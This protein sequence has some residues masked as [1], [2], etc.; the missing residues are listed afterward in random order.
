[1]VFLVY[2]IIVGSAGNL[3][4]TGIVRPYLAYWVPNILMLLAAVLFVY[5]KEREISFNIG[6]KISLLY[7]DAKAMV[8]KT[9]KAP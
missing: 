6:N 9:H 3:A 4:E 1:M 5:I 2:Y 7:Y 8:Q